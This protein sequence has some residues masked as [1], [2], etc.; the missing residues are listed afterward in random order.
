MKIAVKYDNLAKRLAMLND[1][2]GSD[3]V[4]PELFCKALIIAACVFCFLL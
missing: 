1:P 2:V 3:G 4:A